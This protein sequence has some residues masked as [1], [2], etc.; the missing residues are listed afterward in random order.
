MIPHGIGWTTFGVLYGA[1]AAATIAVFL[2]RLARRGRAVAG[3]SW[4]ASP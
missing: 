3:R 2:L 1:L 4:P